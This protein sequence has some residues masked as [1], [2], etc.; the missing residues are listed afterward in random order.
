MYNLKTVKF[1]RKILFILLLVFVLIMPAKAEK[2]EQKLSGKILLQVEDLGQAWYVEPETKKRAFLGR[3]SD[4]FRIMRELGLGISEQDYKN[5]DNIAPA[6]LSGR[7]LLRV[8]SLGEAYYVNPENLNMYYLGRPSDAF[9]LMRELGLGINNANLNQISTNNDYQE[10]KKTVFTS[11]DANS[12]INLYMFYGEGCPHCAKE[13]IFLDELSLD[14]GNI[15][16]NKYETWHNEDN[17]KFYQEIKEKYDYNMNGVP[18]LL[19]GDELVYGF[20]DEETTGS[21]IKQIIERQSNEGSEDIVFP[22]LDNSYLVSRVV[23]GDTID[24]LI[25]NETKRVRII[26]LDTPEVVDP[27]REVECFGPEASAYAKELLEN[28]YVRLEMD[29]TQ[30]IEDKYGRLLRHVILD[31]GR[32]FAEIMISQGYAHEYT[33]YKPYKYQKEYLLAETEAK[34][35]DLGIWAEEAC[36]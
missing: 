36:K 9:Q 4:A 34:Q 8:E 32:S 30:D 28:K 16:I 3:P 21:R 15:V 19:I 6:K 11:S 35:A 5:F 20:G 23:D 25:N 10:D 14:Y 7:I 31:D 24:V 18:F 22:L 12:T 27:R 2:L 13:E 17:R 1:M 26:G 29:S 33:Y